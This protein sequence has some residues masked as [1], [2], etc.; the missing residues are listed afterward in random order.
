MVATPQESKKPP[1][2]SADRHGDGSVGSMG[3]SGPAPVECPSTSS[4]QKENQLT[5]KVRAKPS[6]P[7]KGGTVSNQSTPIKSPPVKKQK[8]IPEHD[9]TAP[10]DGDVVIAAETAL[11]PGDDTAELKADTAQPME[12]ELRTVPDPWYNLNSQGPYNI[13][14][15]II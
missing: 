14:V 9:T 1:V 11:K 6:T 13:Q 8:P 5:G 15:P 7:Q 4:P 2:L 10:E 12:I 3:V